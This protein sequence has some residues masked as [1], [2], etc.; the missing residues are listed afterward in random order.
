MLFDLHLPPLELQAPRPVPD[1]V[2]RDRA[3]P[4]AEG[5]L[6]A[7][8]LELLEG[9]DEGLLHH[10]LD[11]LADP[12]TRHVARH[13]GRVP[14]HEH[15]GGPFVPGEPTRDEREVGRLIRPNGWGRHAVTILRRIVGV[16]VKAR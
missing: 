2:A 5:T 4:G 11:V 13:R 16:A 9:A 10:I 3:E 7:E 12:E 14:F 15:R 6:A 1:E 8:A